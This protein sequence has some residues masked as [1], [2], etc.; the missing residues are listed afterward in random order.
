MYTSLSYHMKGM[1][2]GLYI[3]ISNKVTHLVQVAERTATRLEG[4]RYN[5]GILHSLVIPTY[6]SFT[7]QTVSID[8]SK[9]V[10]HLALQ[11]RDYMEGNSSL[12]FI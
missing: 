4:T 2:T 6:K 11:S 5:M 7:H 10:A 1:L 8:V 9:K 12:L 3:D